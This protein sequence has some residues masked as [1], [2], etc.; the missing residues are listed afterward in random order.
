MNIKKF[1]NKE[2]YVR[3]VLVSFI[4]DVFNFLGYNLEHDR[5]KK[6][7]YAEDSFKSI[8]EEKI[9]RVYD[10]YI[11]LV[12]NA[13]N[14]LT[15]RIL[16]TFFYIYFGKET[17]IPAIQELAA[18]KFGEYGGYAQQYLFCLARKQK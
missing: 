10:A 14:P 11:Y 13:K 12:F 18:E 17:S 15:N 9:K 4:E 7:L 2:L 1:E 16:N 3:K 6:V 8:D 5:I